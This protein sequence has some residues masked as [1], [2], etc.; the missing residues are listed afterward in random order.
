MTLSKLVHDSSPLDNNPPFGF[1][2]LVIQYGFLLH[3]IACG[4]TSWLLLGNILRIFAYCGLVEIQPL[5]C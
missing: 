3:L 1:L 5:N 4:L 2:F